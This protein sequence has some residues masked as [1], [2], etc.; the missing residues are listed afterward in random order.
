MRWLTEVGWS[1]R[2]SQGAD[3]D[4]RSVLHPERVGTHCIP[5]EGKRIEYRLPAM[6]RTHVRWSPPGWFA[7]EV[8]AVSWEGS[9]TRK[10]DSF[11]VNLVPS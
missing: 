10:G 4:R 7:A 9:M 5:R 6:G 3:R 8:E 2:L 11:Q 1:C